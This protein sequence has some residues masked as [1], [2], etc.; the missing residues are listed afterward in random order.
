MAGTA[1]RF[2]GRRIG[3]GGPWVKSVRLEGLATKDRIAP[4]SPRCL[5]LSEVVCQGADSRGALEW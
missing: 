1:S 2:A 4:G 3:D 5:L